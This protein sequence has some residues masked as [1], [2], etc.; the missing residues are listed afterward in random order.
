MFKLNMVFTEHA[1]F[2]YLRFLKIFPPSPCS[3]VTYSNPDSIKFH[4][5]RVIGYSVGVAFTVLDVVFSIFFK[6]LF[7]LLFV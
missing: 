4:A 2:R 7:E 5:S 3:P 1:N 6:P